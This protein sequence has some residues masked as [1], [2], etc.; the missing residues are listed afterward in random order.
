MLGKRKTR[1]LLYKSRRT[2]ITVCGRIVDILVFF[3]PVFLIKWEA[4]CYGLS[5]CPPQ[6]HM[7]KPNALGD[8]TEVND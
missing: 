6:M 7:L 2:A 1:K 8:G 5:V 4:S 3:T